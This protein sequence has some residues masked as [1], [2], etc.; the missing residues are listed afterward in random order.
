MRR[1]QVGNA[2][3]DAYAGGGFHVE[4]RALPFFD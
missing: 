2:V 3:R 1:R 4:V